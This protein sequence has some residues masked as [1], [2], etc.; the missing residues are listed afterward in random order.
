MFYPIEM[1]N[2]VMAFEKKLDSYHIVYGTKNMKRSDLRELFPRYEFCFLKQEHGNQVVK[3]QSYPLMK[4]DAHWTDKKNQALAIYTADCIPLF[5]IRGDIIC[6]IHAGWRGVYKKIV[7]EVLKYHPQL[8]HPDLLV[9]IGPH[10]LKQSFI[11]GED[12]VKKLSLSYP[13]SKKWIDQQNQGKCLVSLMDIVCDQ[14][15]SKIQVKSYYSF[16]KNTF[17]EN[18]FYS[19]RRNTEKTIK[20]REQISFI[21]RV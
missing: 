14:I 8:V 17:L 15:H 7:L 6:A 4:A 20:S 21:V 12:V 3:A 9:S 18:L 11:V 2:K 1:E 5:L 16:V 13:R 10:I 19:F